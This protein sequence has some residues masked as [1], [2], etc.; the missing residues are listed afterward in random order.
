MT[1][2]L[3]R[4][5]VLALAA[6][7]LGAVVS[8]AAAQL[9]DLPAQLIQQGT[10]FAEPQREQVR[11]YVEAFKADLSGE[12]PMAMKRARAKLEEPLNN[13]QVSIAF[14]IEYGR[15]LLPVLETLAR[16]DRDILAANAM[17]LAGELA[18]P[19]ASDLLM[20]TPGVGLNDQRAPVRHA[21]AFGLKRTFE[22]LR[23]TSPVFQER[24]AVRVIDALARRIATEEDPYVL[25]GYARAFEAAVM[26]PQGRVKGLRAAAAAS[27]AG[28]M[29][30]YVRANQD[31]LEA[32]GA[33]IRAA[34]V[35]RDAVMGQGLPADEPRLPNETLR[36]VGGFGGDLIAVVS[37][38]LANPGAGEPDRPR[39]AAI[40]ASGENV[41]YFAHSTLG[42]GTP[43][44]LEL[45]EKVR[46]GRDA[47]FA[48][49]AARY[50]GKSGV[51]TASPF[52]LPADRFQ[53]ARGAD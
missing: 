13:P 52:N 6:L 40:A 36:E 46:N 28:A 19:I 32:A 33:M 35:L 43:L 26:V 30:Q 27:L 37:C 24:D 34:Q 8:P 25:E 2:S 31:R 16:S 29:S 20:A 12:D 9:R 14:R 7:V 4:T 15:H 11:Q 5:R 49:A 48:E 18:T 1:L 3:R 39:L 53:C 10:N 51:L 42:S 38:R 41:Y 45:A 22:H 50:I 17:H 23:A 47:E 44:S 21:A